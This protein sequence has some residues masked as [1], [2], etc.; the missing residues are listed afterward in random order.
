MGG[1]VDEDGRREPAP[2]RSRRRSVALVGLLALATGLVA[3]A[4]LRGGGGAYEPPGDGPVAGTFAVPTYDWDGASAMDAAVAGT[5]W[6]TPRAARSWATPT[7][8]MR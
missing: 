2:G 5:L 3:V 6:F 4:V 8:A 7:A 1:S